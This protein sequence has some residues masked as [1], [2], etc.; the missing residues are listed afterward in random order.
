MVVR[1]DRQILIFGT[2]IDAT[3][4][5]AGVCDQMQVN[6]EAQVNHQE[7][8]KWRLHLSAE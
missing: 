3:L 4:S 8:C 2:D 7:K 6:W 5:L 1:H